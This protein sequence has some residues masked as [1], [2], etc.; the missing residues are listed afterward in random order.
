MNN[1]DIA[2]I[3][4]TLNSLSNHARATLDP[5]PW[6]QAL[7]D[8]TYLHSTRAESAWNVT[9]PVTDITT[10]L[11]ELKASA[12][13]DLSLSVIEEFTDCLR[14]LSSVATRAALA[15]SLLQDVEALTALKVPVVTL[16]ARLNDTITIMAGPKAGEETTAADINQLMAKLALTTTHKNY[17]IYD[18]AAGAGLSLLAVRQL[19]PASQHVSLLGN[20][21][22]TSTLLHAKMTLGLLP[23]TT[24]TVSLSSVDTLAPTTNNEPDAD[25]VISDP[26][27][28]VRWSANTEL[29][30]D[31][32]FAKVNVLPP[33]SKAD[34]AFVLDG[35]AHLKDDGIMV[36]QLP[37]GVLFRGG[38]EGKIRQYL[39]NENVIDAVI[40]LPA[41]LNYSTAIPTMLL[42]LRKHR[43]RKGILFIDASDGFVKSR[44]KNVLTDEDSQKI[45]NTYKAYKDVKSYA[46]VAAP[47][48]IAA[49]DGNLNIPR[50]VSTFTPPEAVSLQ[51]LDQQIKE[52]RTK[53]N[54]LE[55]HSATIMAK[56]R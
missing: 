22:R 28:S 25:I 48:E 34:Y 20:E 18:P 4:T 53:I 33:K 1:E 52:Y 2:K 24:T 8:L 5:Q 49:A 16:M 12:S 14:R 9:L 17:T 44:T 10:L 29:L 47:E 50:Y 51:A 41:N 46:H 39:I 42:V 3:D 19:L 45:V 7:T 38:A 23:K 31:P 54:E 43:T 56:Y 35:L 55:A 11:K 37:H 13:N 40:G 30:E 27:Y 21:I 32:R 6:Y 15:T 36:I 26:P